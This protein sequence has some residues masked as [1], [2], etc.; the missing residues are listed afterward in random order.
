MCCS[1]QLRKPYCDERI[2]PTTA[3]FYITPLIEA[4]LSQALTPGIG[5]SMFGLYLLAGG[6]LLVLAKGWPTPTSVGITPSL[7]SCVHCHGNPLG[8]GMRKLMCVH[9][10]TDVRR[11]VASLTNCA[12]GGVI[13][14]RCQ[15]DGRA[16]SCLANKLC[17]EPSFLHVANVPFVDVWWTLGG[18]QLY[19]ISGCTKRHVVKLAWLTP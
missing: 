11:G 14:S 4:F 2:S 3:S 8:I 1:R 6:R 15:L 12:F 9:C 7:V 13:S 10:W 5:K 19:T 17:L 18:F 16:R